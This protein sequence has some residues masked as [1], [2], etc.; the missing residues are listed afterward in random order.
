VVRDVLDLRLAT[1]PPAIRFAHAM[2][3]PRAIVLGDAAQLFEA[4]NNLCTNAL[5]AMPHGGDVRIET[6]TLRVESD[7]PLSHG[8]LPPGGY[9]RIAVVDE[10][11]G[12]PA[13][14]LEHLFEPFFTTRQS[15]GG[16]GLGLAMVHGAVADMGGAID[17]VSAPERGAAFALY[18]PLGDGALAAD[19]A[20]APQPTPRGRGQVV[21]VVDDEPALV[22]LTE[23]VLAD[24]G[25]EPAGFRDPMLALQVLRS[26]PERFDALLTDQLMPG[27]SGI[28]LARALRALRP[29]A[30]ILLT[31]GF[32]GPDLD[33][34][35][36]DAGVSVLLHK[37][38]QRSELAQQLARLLA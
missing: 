31:T 34:R 22:S 12:M 37:P 26:A 21:M 32:G 27:V 15:E 30:P 6:A 17:V 33:Q 16:N 11:M 29:D 24:L 35:A 14:V 4:L 2:N 8:T 25:Y 9:V 38:L 1:A 36:R 28:E 18:L 3:A 20:P 7:R 23:E 13:E 5:N 19:S 10:G